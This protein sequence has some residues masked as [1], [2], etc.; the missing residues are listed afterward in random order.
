LYALARISSA[1]NRTPFALFSPIRLFSH[2]S[3]PPNRPCSQTVDK[4]SERVFDWRRR[5]TVLVDLLKQCWPTQIK[6][7]FIPPLY[8]ILDVLMFVIRIRFDPCVLHSGLV[9]DRRFPV[10]HSL[11]KIS[12][13]CSYHLILAC[14]VKVLCS[15][16]DSEW[17]EWFRA[18]QRSRRD[19]ESETRNHA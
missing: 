16:I 14:G 3:T 2:L 17:P 15:E 18:V 10:T 4:S 19:F 7:Y 5:L 11:R 8:S 1:R 13:L 12:K 6:L 9:F